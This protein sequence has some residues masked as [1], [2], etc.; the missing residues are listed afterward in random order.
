MNTIV[1][2]KGVIPSGDLAWN[3]LKKFSDEPLEDAI[4]ELAKILEIPIRDAEVMIKKVLDYYHYNNAPYPQDVSRTLFHFIV[5]LTQSF[6][7]PSMTT[8][9]SEVIK[10]IPNTENCKTLLD[11]GAGG[12]KESIIFSK[13]GYK[14]TY[15]DFL[16]EMTS[17][18]KK[19]FDLRNL[20]INIQDVRSLGEERFDAISC[21]DVLEHIYDIEFSMADIISRI[22]P[23][24]DLY[25]YPCFV[26]CWQ[27][28]HKS[29]NCAYNPYF[30]KMMEAVGMKINY[31]IPV[32]S[33]TRHR[34]CFGD[35]TDERTQIRKEL[36]QLSKNYS[37]KFFGINLVK[38]PFRIIKSIFSKD[39]GTRAAK[40]EYAFSQLIDNADVYRLSNHRLIFD[41]GGEQN[42]SPTKS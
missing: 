7:I 28:D 29:K 12:G 5:H 38:L 42:D 41:S 6:R 10:S 3:L 13:F 33:F 32:F 39:K 25:C 40:I 19:R 36:Y 37:K 16:D 9:I 26:N 20:H 2:S 15:S 18:V 17:L 34:P 14:V 27:G 11:Y 31:S 30:G 1:N 23:G 8:R 22:K 4:E 35:V 24:G 21:M